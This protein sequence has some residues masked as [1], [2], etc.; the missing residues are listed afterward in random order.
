MKAA[1]PTHCGQRTRAL[2]IALTLMSCSA[3]ASVSIEINLT[4]QKA[5]LRVDGEVSAETRISS[6][7]ASHP[8][9]TGEF[10][11]IEKELNHFSTLYGRIVT[12]RGRVLRGDASSFDPLPRAARFVPAPMR[13]FIRFKEGYGLHAGRVPG[14]PASHGCVR[15]PRA[16]AEKFFEKAEVGDVVRIHGKAP[17]KTRTPPSGKSLTRR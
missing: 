16:M 13:Y 15:L 14:Y 5:Y 9:P 2:A 1:S 7:C 17:V 11:V 12:L 8:T 3:L 4:E 10:A 6:G